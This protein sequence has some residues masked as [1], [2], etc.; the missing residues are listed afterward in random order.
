MD[1]AL[2]NLQ[3]IEAFASMGSNGV[4]VTSQFSIEKRGGGNF[5]YFAIFVP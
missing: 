1:S 3:E 4:V 5:R 2:K